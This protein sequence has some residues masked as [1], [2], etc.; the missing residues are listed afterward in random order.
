MTS[1]T[2][3]TEPSL[4]GAYRLS[5]EGSAGAT[6]KLVENGALLYEGPD[7]ATTVTG[8]PAGRYEYALSVGDGAASA[9]SCVVEVA[10]PPMSQ[11]LGLLS[12]GALV[13][14]ATLALVVL[15]HRAH[16]REVGE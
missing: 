14:L 2:C 15:G 3:P 13:F 1:L 16:R 12:V 9:A 11:A 4:T 7:A 5:W 8:R 10:P 6:F